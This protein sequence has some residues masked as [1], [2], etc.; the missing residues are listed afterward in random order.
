MV[1]TIMGCLV[2]S[3]QEP[4]NFEEHVS[5]SSELKHFTDLRYILMPVSFIYCSCELTGTMPTSMVLCKANTNGLDLH[6][7]RSA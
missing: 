3:T 2:K 1:Q 6:T 4:C 7:R 5:A